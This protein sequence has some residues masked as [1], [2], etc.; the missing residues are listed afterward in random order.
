MCGVTTQLAN[1]FPETIRLYC[2]LC[3]LFMHTHP[4]ASTHTHTHTHHWIRVN[5]G[6]LFM[7]S[8]YV[9]TI[10]VFYPSHQVFASYI[11]KDKDIFIF[12]SLFILLLNHEC[13]SSRRKINIFLFKTICNQNH[14][15]ILVKYI[16]NV[17]VFSNVQEK[18]NAK[19]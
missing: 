4:S 19:Q 8:V 16:L 5:S 17:K 2:F 6:N 1:F 7:Y 9:T 14:L 12:I 15:M 18:K 10:Y 13:Q 3:F 11:F